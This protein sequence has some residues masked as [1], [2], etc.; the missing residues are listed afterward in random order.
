M[1]AIK[2]E[3]VVW[4][5]ALPFVNI[6]INFVVKKILYQILNAQN[7]NFGMAIKEWNNALIY[8]DGVRNNFLYE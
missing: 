3:I 1:I 7:I 6:L 5:V 2:I 8:M 4:V